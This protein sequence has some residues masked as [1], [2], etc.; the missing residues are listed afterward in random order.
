MLYDRSPNR[1]EHDV[2]G[3]R[4]KI[5]VPIDQDRFVPAL[6]GMAAALMATVGPLGE[7]PVQLSHSLDQ[8]RFRGFDHKMIMVAH[9]TVRMAAPAKP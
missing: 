5:R 1:I 3:Q 4:Q 9:Q 7:N 2:A 6:E 8:I